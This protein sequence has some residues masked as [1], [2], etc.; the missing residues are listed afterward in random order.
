MGLP[1]STLASTIA[2]L[3]DPVH[4]GTGDDFF[5]III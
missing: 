2:L 1:A 4:L 3:G 5:D